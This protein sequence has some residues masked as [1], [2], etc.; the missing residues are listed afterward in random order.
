VVERFR[1]YES[2]VVEK[3]LRHYTKLIV[4]QTPSTKKKRR[5]MKTTTYANGVQSI[6]YDGL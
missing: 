1:M 4:G 6:I 5:K 3:P 2:K